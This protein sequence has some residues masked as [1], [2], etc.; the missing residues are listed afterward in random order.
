LL[1]DSKDLDV[2]KLGADKVKDADV[3]VYVGGLDGRTEAE[4]GDIRGVFKGFTSGDRDTIE[5]PECQTAMIKALVAT[6]K[7]VVV[8]NMTGS[9]TAMPWE[10][11]NARAIVQ[12]WYPGEAGG[13]AIADLLFGAYNPSGRLPVTF[14]RATADLPAFGDYAMKGRTYRYF[15][16]KPLWAF[17]HGLSYTTFSYGEMS[18]DKNEAGAADVVKVALD[19]TNSGAMAGEEVVQVYARPAVAGAGDALQRLVGFKR[20]ALTP[21]QKGRVEVAVPIALLRN[22][23]VAKKAY[24]VPAGRHELWAGA[25]SSDARSKTAITIK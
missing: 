18:I 24:V 3:I 21:G 8:V 22:W 13:T 23:D 19:V 9:A 17:G 20:I 10:A 5:M 4:E 2:T 25:S 7:P 11:E 14:Y 16:G 15:T 1:W 6:G 12:A